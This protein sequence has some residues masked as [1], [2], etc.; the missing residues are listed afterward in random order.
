MLIAISTLSV[1]LI[2]LGL[3][4]RKR[5]EIHMSLMIMAFIIDI[6]LVMYIEWSR[7]ALQELTG[8]AIDPVNHELL[9]FHAMASLLTIVLYL[10]QFVTGVILFRG[11]QVQR[12]LHRTTGILFVICRLLNYV[13]GFMVT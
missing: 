5:A 6:G 2:G 12:I 9:I 8:A 1:V 10:V 4:F 13:T 3:R 7:H 11:G